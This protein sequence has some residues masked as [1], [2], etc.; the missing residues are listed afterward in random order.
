M[1]VYS[2]IF[3]LILIFCGC[4]S[5][6]K[7][8]LSHHDF[9]LTVEFYPS[10]IEPCRIVLQKKGDIETL[11]I[12]KIYGSERMRAIDKKD[13][14]I[15]K[16]ALLI[17]K[18]YQ[19]FFG[20]TIF[21]KHIECVSVTKKNFKA[22]KDSI[23]N[24]DLTKQKSLVKEGILDGITIYFRF[25]TDSINNQFSLRCPR[26]SDKSEFQIIKSV[27]NIIESS[28]K[29]ESANN[30]IEQLKGYFDFGLLVKHISDNPLEY[31]FYSH[32]SSNEADE[33]NKLMKELPNDE[34]IV[35][36]FS[37]FRDMG[38]MFYSDFQD[39]IKRNPNVYWIVNDYSEKQV[40]EIGV[41]PEKLFKDRQTLI[42][43]IKNAP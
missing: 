32:L 18:G 5:D 4:R 31:R 36:D 2:I 35:I 42:N 15:D 12:D 6:D 26:P 25:K 21:L 1:K 39:L 10:F 41:K 43:K 28:F 29:T 19:Q 16:N 8:P 20:D 37:N 9:I 22:F 11:S 34:P 40:L 30:Y 17:D 13:L 27:F 38:T 23:I 3:S 7:S 24:I 33:F 14:L